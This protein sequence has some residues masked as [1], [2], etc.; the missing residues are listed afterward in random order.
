MKVS[1]YSHW[2]RER[3]KS[4]GWDS[5]RGSEKSL[6]RPLDD[7]RFYAFYEDSAPATFL[8]AVEARLG[9]VESG[10]GML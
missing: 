1:S 7:S 10:L 5:E 3:G 8:F 4:G 2:K 6:L 9:R